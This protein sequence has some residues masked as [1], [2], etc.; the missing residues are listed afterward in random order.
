MEFSIGK[1]ES[2]CRRLKLGF[3][4][5]EPDL[6]GARVNGEK[7]IALMDDVPIIEMYS[8]KRAADL[9]AQIDLVDRGK[10]PKEA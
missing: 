10:L 8:C 2:R 7:E 4:L 3:G 6:I 1:H 9:S 5:S